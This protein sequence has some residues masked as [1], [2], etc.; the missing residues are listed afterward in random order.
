M[1]LVVPMLMHPVTD[2]LLLY[3]TASLVQGLTLSVV[4][5]LR[6]ASKRL[7]FP[8]PSRVRAK[9]RLAG[10]NIRSNRPSISP[11]E[12]VYFHGLSAG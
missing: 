7:L 11:A 5:Q 8:C 1:A 9:W 10:P 2:V 12:I 6:I 4:F 3:L